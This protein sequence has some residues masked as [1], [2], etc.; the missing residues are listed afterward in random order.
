MILAAHGDERF[1]YV[2]PNG[3]C[4]VVFLAVPERLPGHPPLVGDSKG[5]T[6]SILTLKGPLMNDFIRSIEQDRRS[7]FTQTWIELDG[8][9]AL[10]RTRFGKSEFGDLRLFEDVFVVA[11]DRV[12]HLGAI[13]PG[14]DRKNLE[15]KAYQFWSTFKVIGKGV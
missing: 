13:L 11:E 12:Y 7:M 9:K 5:C 4:S 6:L 8:H 3:D 10:R 2:S 1:K 15:S 14:E